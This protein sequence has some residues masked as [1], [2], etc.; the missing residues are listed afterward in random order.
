MIHPLV[1]KRKGS[2][3]LIHGPDLQ[4]L[5]DNPRPVLWCNDGLYGMIPKERI[6]N[7]VSTL[8]DVGHLARKLSSFG[9]TWGDVVEIP[10]ETGRAMEQYNG[11][12]GEN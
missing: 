2:T 7:A 11:H 3:L 5:V 8:K 1:L 12:N 9:F 10:Q 4:S 6:Q